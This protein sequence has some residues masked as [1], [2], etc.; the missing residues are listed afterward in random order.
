ME[1]AADGGDALGAVEVHDLVVVGAGAGGLALAVLA[2]RA[3][4]DDVVVLERADGVGGTWRV[5]TYPGAE[6]DVPSH[7]YSYS[8]ALNPGW[9][10]TFAG[11]A[12][13]LAYFERCAAEAG[14]VDRIRTSSGVRSLRWDDDGQRWL[15][16]TEAGDRL[17]ARVVV[18]AVGTFNAPAWPDLA[19]LDAFAGPVLHSARWDHDV[20]LGGH[21]V[22]VVGTGASAVQIV[23]AIADEVGHLDVFQRSAPWI[24]PR[25][26]APYADEA[27][28]AFAADVMAMR[29]HRRAFEQLYEGNTVFRIDDRRLASFERHALAHLEASVA[30][31]DLR[32]A[33]TPDYPIGC[34]RVL[35]SD[36]YYP[37]LQ[38]DHVDLVTTPIREVVADGV[39]TADGEH[40]PLDVLV[41]ATGYHATDY[42]H[43]IDVVG[44]DGRDLHAEWA[45]EPRAHLGV[46]VPGFPNLF[47]LYGPNTNQGGNSI[48]LILEAQARYVVQAL[49]EMHERGIDVLEV[50]PE[51][52]AEYN[53]QLDDDLAATIW[54][55]CD[56]YFR[57][58]SGHIATQ[59]PHP[60]AWYRRRTRR[61]DLDD[62]VVTPSGG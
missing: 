18:S 61:I 10:K 40:R 25:G 11:Q 36:D 50:R 15:V 55:S 57:T 19:G 42:L 48:L 56:S 21:R 53:R 3:G 8:F 20:E 4:I 12:E 49:R 9:S 31:P 2:G 47:V 45:D 34:K 52:F 17:R 27:R 60:A 16:T 33:L 14:V 1:A 59:L 38:Q 13:I 26:D 28:A 37:A 7:L 30:D 6:C 5:N 58:A 23:P 54:A 44:R 51:V 46:A 41:L 24:M 22:G 39:V 32:A 62:Y 35:L 43:G 29:R